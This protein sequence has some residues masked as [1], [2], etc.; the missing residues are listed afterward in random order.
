MIIIE[1]VF[2]GDARPKL[3]NKF[4]LLLCA[5]LF[6]TLNDALPFAQHEGTRTPSASANQ[7]IGDRNTKNNNSSAAMAE[8]QAH[9]LPQTAVE[10]ARPLGLP[11]TT[12]MVVSW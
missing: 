1:K 11:L 8:T 4:G 12:S 6:M 7:V 3:D 10:I 5:I 9:R 2:S